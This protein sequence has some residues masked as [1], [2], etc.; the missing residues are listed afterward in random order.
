MGK[1][2][3]LE[4]ARLANQIQGFRIPNRLEAGEKRLLHSDF[5][6][7]RIIKVS[8]RVITPISTLIIWT[9]QKPHPLIVSGPVSACI[10]NNWK[11]LG[12]FRLRCLQTASRRFGEYRNTA[13]FEILKNYRNTARKIVQYSKHQC[14]P[15]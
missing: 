10:R 6:M 3:P 4:R 12:K 5:V 13:I 11:R 1:S 2:V 9:S 15:L 8:V 14:L 7:S